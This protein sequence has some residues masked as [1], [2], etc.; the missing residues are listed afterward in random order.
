M[1]PDRINRVSIAGSEGASHR[2]KP[3]WRKMSTSDISGLMH[4]ADKIHP[5]LPETASVFTE[6]VKL[7]PAGCLVL[8][9]GAEIC[10]YAIS[11]PIRHDEPPALDS[12]LGE[13]AQDADQYYIHDLAILSKYRGQGLA[14]ECIEQ[15]F[16]IAKSYPTTTLISVYGTE[17]FWGRF[18]F[19]PEPMGAKLLEKVR[20]Y[21]QDARYLSKKNSE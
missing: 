2:P 17:C 3:F 10:G 12:L 6:R 5:E 16:A 1:D 14:A 18:G 11:H 4:V 8:V 19:V 13:I 20:G 15:I 9:D 7:S 21:G